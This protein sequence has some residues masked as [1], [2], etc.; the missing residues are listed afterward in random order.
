MKAGAR[1]PSAEQYLQK[2]EPAQGSWWPTFAAWLAEHPTRR[3]SRRRRW[4]TAKK[5]L[6]PIAD[7]PGEYVLAK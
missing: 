4:A 2:V 5:G 3:G 6:K 1:L 7:A